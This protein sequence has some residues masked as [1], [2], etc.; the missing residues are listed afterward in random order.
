M[1][2]RRSASDEPERKPEATPPAPAEEAK[3]AEEA[4]AAEEKKAE[5]PKQERGWFGRMLEK[6]GL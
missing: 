4:K 3:K 6:I 5:E 1:A 2:H